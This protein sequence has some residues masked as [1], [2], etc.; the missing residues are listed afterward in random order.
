MD[1]TD[2]CLMNDITT[3]LLESPANYTLQQAN[4]WCWTQ[5]STFSPMYRDQELAQ[6][7]QQTLNG[8]TDSRPEVSHLS[9]LTPAHSSSTSF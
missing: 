1:S 9:L 3:S 4:G 6:A 2:L 5:I 8:R 7:Y